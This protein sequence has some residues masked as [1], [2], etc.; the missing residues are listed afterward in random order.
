M[1][2]ELLRSAARAAIACEV[3]TGCPAPLLVAQWAVES[4]WGKRAPGNN[5]FGIKA[6]DGDE[7]QLLLTREWF[8]DAEL[9]RFI[10]LGDGRDAAPTGRANALRKEYT[11]HDWFA[12]FPSLTACFDRRAELFR[13]GRYAPFAA[14]Y[15]ADGNV[16]ALVRG[17]AP[18]YATDPGYADAI[19]RVIGMQS[20]RQALLAGSDKNETISV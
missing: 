10:A 7:R 9:Q 4:A 12:K 17:I 6:R 13:K 14:K 16:E 15:D 19:L 18:I 11:V 8:T 3:H 20:T 1:A 2:D 5:C